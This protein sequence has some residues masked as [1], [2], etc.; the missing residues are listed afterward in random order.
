M[1]RPLIYTREKDIISVAKDL[2]IYKN[3]CPEDRETQR[4]FM[5]DLIKNI[6]K[7]IPFAKDRM[8]GA[9]INSERYNLWDKYEKFPRET[10]KKD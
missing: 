6:Q 1:I 7:N 10:E 4:E 9:I 3:P 2:P 8:L 5:K